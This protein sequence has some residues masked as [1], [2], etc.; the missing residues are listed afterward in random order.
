MFL[1]VVVPLAWEWSVSSRSKRIGK[2]MEG[3]KLCRGSRAWLSFLSGLA[4]E[5]VEIVEVEWIDNVNV[6]R[7]WELPWLPSCVYYSRWHAHASAM[8]KQLVP[9]P[10][11][12]A[13]YGTPSASS[14]PTASSPSWEV[15][16]ASMGPWPVSRAAT[17]WRRSRSP[18]RHRKSFRSAEAASSPLRTT[19]GGKIWTMARTGRNWGR[20]RRDAMHVA[21]RTRVFR[22][23]LLG[24]CTKFITQTVFWDEHIYDRWH[25][26]F[27]DYVTI[28]IA[29]WCSSCVRGG[30]M[31]GLKPPSRHAGG[32]QIP[33]SRELPWHHCYW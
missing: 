7:V 27:F 24:G 6:F 16:V 32:T 8:T 17:R 28:K 11:C 3:V 23:Q 21:G 13:G 10:L 1:F 22:Q 25:R 26:L 19:L 5:I 29:M 12:Q 14:A 2:N 18:K 30:N 4:W 15:S 33:R 31:N 20:E 9:M